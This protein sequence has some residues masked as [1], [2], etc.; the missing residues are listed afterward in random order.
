MARQRAA[1][2]AN[3]GE[4]RN[5]LRWMQKSKGCE[6]RLEKSQNMFGAKFSVLS[7][8]ERNLKLQN[9]FLNSPC[10]GCFVTFI[11][12]LFQSLEA[13]HFKRRLPI[14]R[15]GLTSYI[16]FWFLVLCLWRFLMGTMSFLSTGGSFLSPVKSEWIILLCLY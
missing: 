16:A 15:R 1:R 11:G 10:V 6:E 14:G 8:Y 12:R 7:V 5:Q 3:V 2:A 4:D 9:S 13:L